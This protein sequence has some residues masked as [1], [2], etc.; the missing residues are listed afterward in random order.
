MV[1]I[2][3]LLA[4]W[5]NGQV[6]TRL[7][8]PPVLIATASQGLCFLGECRKLATRRMVE[9]YEQ[10]NRLKNCDLAQCRAQL[11]SVSFLC[12][13]VGTTAVSPPSRGA[14]VVIVCRS[15]WSEPRSAVEGQTP[16]SS[17]VR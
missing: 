16:Q 9:Q 12:L 11:F 7:R 6:V 13:H 3:T 15:L 10:G 1:E 14:A 5:Q 17:K 4:R 2:A 8:P